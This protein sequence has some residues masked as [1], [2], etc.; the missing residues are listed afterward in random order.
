[1]PIT[2]VTGPANAGKA[3]VLLDGVRAWA[4][5]GHEPL[6]VVPTRPDVEH[7]RRELAEG[8]LV[9]GVRVERFQGLMREVIRRAG[10]SAQRTLSPLARERLLAVA[11]S[12]AYSGSALATRPGFL[13]ALAAF[14][15][16][17]EVERV[18]PQRLRRALHAWAADGDS[19]AQRGT[20]ALQLSAL[21]ESYHGML[22]EIA[23]ADPE[24]QAAQALDAVRRSPAL[25][26]GTPVVLYGFDDLTRLQLDTV[27]TLGRVVGAPL[28][29]SLPFQPGRLAF[30]G[31]AST[32]QTLLP[33]ASEHRRLPARPEHYEPAARRA[34]HHLEQGL[35]EP[36][37]QRIEPGG[38]V[39]L[40]EGGS[41]RA[42]LELVA[43][44]IRA[45]L[46]AGMAAEE[47]AVVHRSP[48]AV[49]ELLG[50]VL[51]D[52]GIPFAL[53]RR[54][55]F[56]HTSVGR[57][58]CG[59]LMA[60]CGGIE[61]LPQG[62]LADL[63][64]WLRAPGLLE[65]PELV[66]R[67]EAKARRM[68]IEDAAQAQALWESEHWPLGA[69]SEIRAAAQLAEEGRPA[70]LAE[71]VIREL[72]WLFLAPRR[73][74]AGLLADEEL[75]EA[76]ALVLAKGALDE[77]KEL[78]RS[79]PQ[80]A[81]GPAELLRVL[82][83]LELLSGE[84]AGP[85][86][87]AVLD[88]LA[89]RARRVRALFLCGLQ[90]GTFPAPSRPE[91]LLS[92]DERRALAEASGLRLAGA[93]QALA[94][95]RYLLYA[96]VSRPQELLVLSWHA[97]ADNGDPTAASLFLDDVCDL[98]SED[99][100]S[101]CARRSLGAADWPGPGAA[102]AEWI[103]RA[104]I[105][106]SDRCA[107]QLLQP[108]RDERL[109]A[110]LREGRLW[111]ASSLEAWAGCP[112]RWLV[113]RVLRAKGLE[114]DP[115]PLARGGLAHIA[116]KD[117]LE[118]LRQ[119]TGSARLTLARLELAR[120]LLHE[121]LDRHADA[122]PLSVAPE[123]VPGVRRRLEADLERYLEHAAAQ[124]SPLEPTHLELSFGFDSHEHELP[125]LDIG[126]GVRLRGRIDRV[127]LTAAGEAVVYDYKGSQAP[128]AEKWVG[129]RSLQVTL[130]MRAVEEL[131]GR[132][133]VGGFYQPLSGRDL[134]ARGALASEAAV[135]LQCVI[136]DVCEHEDFQMLWRETLDLARTAAQE[137]D[138]GALQARPGTCAF[139]DGGCL[140]PAICRCE[141]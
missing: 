1:V 59:M 37:A 91:P 14:V 126:G 60:G 57:A 21:F 4:M 112:A 87:V 131:L 66:D 84:P 136:G 90:E 53:Q 27:E 23:R 13:S 92:E 124:E 111:S 8:G 106:G 55:P 76:R 68:G 101:S 79:A 133:V 69:L 121:A 11:A 115:E 3:R 97:A 123:R 81:S 102:P 141:R 89:L 65:H 103:Q 88:P 128:P 56:C 137:A 28:M 26:G 45:L 85:G 49:A 41:P 36:E 105:L 73:R 77:L 44:E 20:R 46:D 114:P 43:G 93:D 64:A 62:S 78:A 40:L 82:K 16:E 5:R 30:G 94:G 34:L 117:T 129:Q 25:W 50:E 63:L 98:F 113:E 42:E 116:L 99:L 58:V 132:S 120:K 83:R 70:A 100:R 54:L 130:Y 47:I 125:P 35:F 140:Y 61:G 108:L 109:L 72:E 127:D 96:S 138:A 134:R 7:Y 22:R 75:D 31:R 39:R 19:S 135:Q 48:A 38:A 104:Q 118:G 80:L 32:F 110:E 122:F 86:T 18:T 24:Q 74:T 67:L 12:S 139:G 119:Q 10:G 29:V 51:G 2:L 107:P 17:L 71:R 9:L 52:F 33:S 95:E 15:A 6:L